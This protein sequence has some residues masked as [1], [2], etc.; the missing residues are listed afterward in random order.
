MFQPVLVSLSKF[1]FSVLVFCSIILMYSLHTWFL[2]ILNFLQ[3]LCFKIKSAWVLSIGLL[4]LCSSGGTG[5]RLVWVHGTATLMSHCCGE[6]RE[7]ERSGKT[8]GVQS[9]LQ[10]TE[11]GSITLE[12][13]DSLCHSFPLSYCVLGFFFFSLSLSYLLTHWKHG[14]ASKWVLS[15]ISFKC[16]F[17]LLGHLHCGC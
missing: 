15:P 13:S 6:S 10:E 2:A 3:N 8:Q 4:S 9:L 14:L 12:S 5:G 11:K 17:S 16:I 7:L 1:P